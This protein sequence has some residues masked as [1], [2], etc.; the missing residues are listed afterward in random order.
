M[1]NAQERDRKLDQAKGKVKRAGQA[2]GQMA[3]AVEHCR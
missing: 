1:R 3:S 2:I